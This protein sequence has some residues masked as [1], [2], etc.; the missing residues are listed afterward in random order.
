MCG[1]ICGSTARG[2]SSARRA[3]PAG[4]AGAPSSSSRPGPAGTWSLTT[5]YEFCSLA[6]CADGREPLATPVMDTSGDL[7][8]TT[9]K[10]GAHRKG[11]LFKLTPSPGGW[12]ESVLHDFCDEKPCA[13]GNEPGQVVLDSLGRVFGTTYR[14]K[15]GSKDGG[16][17]F[18]W[19][20]TYQVLYNFCTTEKRCRD[21]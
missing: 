5:L 7:Y 18:R 19:D 6:D 15:A 8:G 17:V 20:G 4:M 12:Q 2:I 13:D 1:S 14:G 16:T 10:G 9:G 3:K 11:T 21:G